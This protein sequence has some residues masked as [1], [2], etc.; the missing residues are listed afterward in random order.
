MQKISKEELK[1]YKIIEQLCHKGPVFVEENDLV[2]MD[3]NHY[4]KMIKSIQEAKILYTG[5]LDESAN[6]VK[7][8]EVVLNALKEKYEL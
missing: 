6:R 7:D 2:V 3:M 4:E 1:N 8:G 5:L